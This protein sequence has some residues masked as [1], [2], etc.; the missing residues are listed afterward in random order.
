MQ[1][2]VFSARDGTWQS[3][4]HGG[5]GISACAALVI[6][7]GIARALRVGR[8]AAVSLP[9]PYDVVFRRVI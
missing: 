8:C 2:L 9:L 4:G 7:Q 5:P 1:Q 6:E 3:A